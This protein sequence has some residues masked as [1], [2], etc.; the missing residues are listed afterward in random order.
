MKKKK[1]ESRWWC[2]TVYEPFPD[3]E[4][5]MKGTNIRFIAYGLE[6]CPTSGKL[7]HQLYCYFRNAISKSKRNCLKVGK[8]FTPDKPSHAEGMEGTPQDSESYCS[9]EGELIKLGNEPKQGQRT[10]IM[11]QIDAIVNNETTPDE[12]CLVNPEFFH[13]YGRTLDRA[14]QI[15][16][17]RQWRKH[18]TTGTWIHGE[19]GSGKSHTAFEDFNPLTHYVKN[20]REEWWD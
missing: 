20:L 9:K 16:L 8:M 5:V 4:M 14:F 15:V 3:Y 12:L 17:R 2:V 7:H 18:M 6:T 19:S 10:D 1:E 13:Q 11:E